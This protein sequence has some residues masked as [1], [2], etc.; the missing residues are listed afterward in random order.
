MNLWERVKRG[1]VDQCSFGFEIREEE[2]DFRDDG[3]VHWTIKDVELYEVSCCTFPAYSETQ[4]S[5]R[6]AERDDA[7][8]RSLEA[9][10][11]NNLRRIKHGSES[12]ASEEEA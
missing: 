6:S 12:P 5:A 2:T 3:S 8:R 11:T 9:W 10:K 7:R 4:I 1:D